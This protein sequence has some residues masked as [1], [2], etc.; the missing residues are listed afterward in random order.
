MNDCIIK[1]TIIATCA[2][3]LCVSLVGCGSR[4][5]TSDDKEE[6]TTLTLAVF[7]GS[8]RLG[9]AVRKY[10]EISTQYRVEIIQYERTDDF[11][12]NGIAKLQRE[13]MSGG[14]PDLISYG[15]GFSTSDITG[16]YTEDLFSFLGDVIDERFCFINILDA[17]SHD[18]KLYCMPLSFSLQTFAGTKKMLGGIERWTVDEMVECY[19]GRTDGVTLYPGETKQDVFGTLMMTN[20]DQYIDWET[21]ECVFNEESFK[22]I[23]YFSGLFPDVPEFTEDY[24]IRTA[25]SNG[26]AMLLPV[27]LSG[28]FDIKKAEYILGDKEAVFVG[29][30]SDEA[31]GSV[32]SPGN[33]N[34]AVSIG[35]GNKEGAKDFLLFL[36]DG[37]QQA[38]VDDGFPIRRDVLLEKMDEACIVSYEANGN[39]VKEAVVR[40][41]ILL[42]GEEPVELYCLERADVEKLLD[43]IDSASF[44]STMNLNLYGILLEEADQYLRGERDLDTTAE[45]IQNRVSILVNERTF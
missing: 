43:Q 8:T 44:A 28:L 24:S 15:A 12:D 32:I 11:L 37:E 19:L 45:N 3:L 17:F 42:E 16:G 23:L 34:I 41:R 7:D 40:D 25:F 39:G 26:E 14:G 27:R 6:R 5:R 22:N 1:K 29:F 10:N 18:G 20:M 21:G 36:L 38:A 13:I 31:S 2:L 4:E 35:S 9:E 30:P 33:M